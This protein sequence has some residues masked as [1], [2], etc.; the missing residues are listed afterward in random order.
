MSCISFSDQKEQLQ[1]AYIQTL[2]KSSTIKNSLN[3]TLS[4]KFKH[5]D[6]YIKT[7]MQKEEEKK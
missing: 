2:P 6:K 4:Q 1:S 7:H 3:Q 5:P